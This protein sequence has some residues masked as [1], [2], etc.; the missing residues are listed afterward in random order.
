MLY[1]ICLAAV[2]VPLLV[3]YFMLKRWRG[4][5]PVCIH[6]H[7]TRGKSGTTRAIA[8][9]LRAGGLRVLAKTTGDRAEYVR[10]DGSVVSVRRIGPPRIKEHVDMMR[11]AACMGADAVVAEGMALQ[12]E[13]VFQSEK[14]L[15]ASHAV[16]TNV[17]PDH[18]ETMGS[19]R[20]GVLRT[21]RHMI[22]VSGKLFTSDEEGAS[23]LN[24]HA[25]SLNIP[26]HLV[27]ASAI[28]QPVA[29]A[30]AVTASVLQGGGFAFESGFGSWA[31]APAPLDLTTDGTPMR[32][33]DLLSANDVVS[34]QL[35]LKG[36][37]SGVNHLQVALLATRA[38]RPLR[39][40]DFMTWIL[41]EARFDT[42]VVMGGHAGY[43]LLRG[44]HEKSFKRLL[45]VRPWLAPERLL[46]ILRERAA[47]GEEQGVT[48]YAL[49]NVHGYGERWRKSLERLAE[50]VSCSN[51]KFLQDEGVGHA[52]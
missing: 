38:D 20:Q 32:A 42:V 12:P 51:R 14:I 16:I 28:E 44:F 5:V 9:L 48:L 52:H 35:L 36:C 39:T 49:G 19:G 30:R 24:E 50:A 15:H 37:P 21:L 47:E 45:I 46:S 43:A 8:T 23:A 34:S 27:G 25:R 22:P 33:Y 2:F 31:A 4:K 18:A 26:F 3:E 13:T 29:L 40:R 7:G 10:P 6:V 1:L 41:A 17:R 11:K